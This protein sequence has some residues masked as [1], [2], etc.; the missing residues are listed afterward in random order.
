MLGAARH[1]G[2]GDAGAFASQ[3]LAVHADP[4][5]CGL[6]AGRARETASELAARLDYTGIFGLDI[7]CAPEHGPMLV[8]VNLRPP[9]SL[10]WMPGAPTALASLLIPGTGPAASAQGPAWRGG[11]IVT[12]KQAFR[13][14]AAAARTLA[15]WGRDSENAPGWV[16]DLPAAG[17]YFAA[18]A[19]VCTVSALAEDE[20]TL[21]EALAARSRQVE[22]LVSGRSRDADSA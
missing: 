21:G 15:E 20:A 16:H 5:A 8:D 4:A 11:A 6:D 2:S 7:V 12:A 9:A 14:D 18:G 1:L 22:A 13:L 10:E 19:P 17:Q 3:A